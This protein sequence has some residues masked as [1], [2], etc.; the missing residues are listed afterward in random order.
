MVNQNSLMSINGKPN[1]L[2]SIN[3][4]PNSLMSINDK[5]NSLTLLNALG[6]TRIEEKELA[7]GF[8]SFSF[9]LLCPPDY[10]DNQTKVD[11]SQKDL[12]L[13]PRQQEMVI[14]TQPACEIHGRCCPDVSIPV[15]NL[16]IKDSI[17]VVT[18]TPKPELA[19]T[20]DLSPRLVCYHFFLVR[21][22]LPDYKENMTI[23][24][25]CEED[26]PQHQQTSDVFI[27]TND[28]DIEIFYNNIY[29]I[30]CNNVD[31]TKLKKTQLKIGQ[32]YSYNTTTKQSSIKGQFYMVKCENRR[33]FSQS[34][35]FEQIHVYDMLDQDLV[36][37]CLEIKDEQFMIQWFSN[38]DVIY[39]EN[40]FC[41][42]SAKKY[43]IPS[44]TFSTDSCNTQVAV[45]LPLYVF[46]MLLNFKRTS[47]ETENKILA[48]GNPL[49]ETSNWLAPDGRQL[50]I[51]CA[52][53]KTLKKNNC[54]DST[55]YDSQKYI[56]CLGFILEKEDVNIITTR[57]GGNNSITKVMETII[58]QVMLIDF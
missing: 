55:N 8:Y 41:A 27:E 22:C 54:V 44:K 29:C 39:F 32:P 46:S 42:I 16:A 3:G 21:S 18:N 37:A 52:R 57:F 49:L 17:G 5:P 24:K 34:H 38:L 4:K 58:S 2:M 45:E 6:L 36:K 15:H 50:K 14:Y 23:M 13:M 43:L 48:K 33:D 53:G 19:Q 10:K 51:E 30:I 11:L 26:L 25:L 7:L 9:V 56:S 31:Q 28:Y 35:T 1:S 40:I 20:D 12:P 47:L